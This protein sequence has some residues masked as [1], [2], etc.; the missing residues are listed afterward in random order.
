MS[1]RPVSED[2]LCTVTYDHSV[3]KKR[4]NMN[5]ELKNLILFPTQCYF[6]CHVAQLFQAEI[7]E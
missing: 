2:I 5:S 6:F 7:P 4:S 1:L 3:E